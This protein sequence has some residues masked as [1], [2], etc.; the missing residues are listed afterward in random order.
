MVIYVVLNV[1]TFRSPYFES[2]FVEKNGIAPSAIV[3]LYRHI[4]ENCKH[5]S[6]NGLMTIGRFGHDYSIGPNPDFICL[7]DC[8]NNVCKTFNLLPE[9]VYI[10]MGMSDDFEQAVSY[11]KKTL[12][13]M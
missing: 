4:I 8:H 7:L 12:L 6:A 2:Y 1:N 10:S 9:N 13:Q 5:L 3:E 11:E